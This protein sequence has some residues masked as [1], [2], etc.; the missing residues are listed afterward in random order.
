MNIISVSDAEYQQLLDIVTLTRDANQLRRAQAL[1]WLSNG[2]DVQEVAERLLVTRQTV[3]PWRSRF[4]TR[5]VLDVPTRLADAHRSGRPRTVSGIIEPLL[6]TVLD[7][8]PRPYGYPSTVW[9]APLRRH[10]LQTVHGLAVS[11]R[12]VG[13]ALARL[14]ITWHRPRHLLGQRAPT[15]RQ[16]KG[17]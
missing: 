15:W 17:G 3:Y 4:R 7:E 1:L 2:E 5:T 12:S 13:L 16:A 9:T 10:Y 11:L 14:A 6:L 8:D